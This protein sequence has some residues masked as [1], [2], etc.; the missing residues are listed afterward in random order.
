MKQVAESDYQIKCEA[1]QGILCNKIWGES[2]IKFKTCFHLQV[3]NNENTC[4]NIWELQ[5]DVE[6][7][8]WRQIWSVKMKFMKITKAV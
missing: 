5:L 8:W 6:R 1:I 2:E 3:Y 7:I 4:H